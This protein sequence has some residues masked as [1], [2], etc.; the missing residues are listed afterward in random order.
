MNFVFDRLLL[1]YERYDKGRNIEKKYFKYYKEE[2]FI[3]Y[4]ED[5]FCMI[6][7]EDGFFKFRRVSIWLLWGF[8]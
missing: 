2:F 4:R 1:F 8:I 7:I 3:I 6:L 5:N